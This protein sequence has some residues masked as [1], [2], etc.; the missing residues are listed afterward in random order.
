MKKIVIIVGA[1][2]SGKTGLSLEI[3]KQ[4]NGAI[5]SGDSIQQYQGFDI[6]S[7]KILANQQEGIDH[8]LLDIYQPKDKTDVASFQSMARRAI[9]IIDAKHQLPII[10]GGTGLYIKSV[11]YD[12]EFSEEKPL[13]KEQQEHLESLSNEYLMQWLQEV[14]PVSAEKIHVNNR[15]RLLRALTLYLTHDK[16]KSEHEALQQH[17]P[18]YD[19]YIVSLT[20]PR[21]V[22]HQRI[23]IRVDQMVKDGLVT[24]IKTLLENGVSFDDQ[25]M[26][27][28]GYKEFKPYFD[29]ETSL[30]ECIASVKTHS[31]QFAK[32]QETFFRHQFENVH[33]YDLSQVDIKSIV[34]DINQW[35]Q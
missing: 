34:E 17:K 6:G 7:G 24:E 29:G 12:Y 5:I 19:A 18:I 21:E 4:F 33:W 11:L 10:C 14:D 22:L 32:R 30:E 25:P 16:S 1:T 9:D 15:V 27:G 23:S 13:S 31:N 2:A 8:Y 20:W 26:K 3:A 28:I 35:L